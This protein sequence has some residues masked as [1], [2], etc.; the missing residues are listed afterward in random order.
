M[1]TPLYFPHQATDMT[2]DPLTTQMQHT[3]SRLPEQR[4]AQPSH[5]FQ[6]Y[7]QLLAGMFPSTKHDQVTL[8][9]HG[10]DEGFI[11]PSG[12]QGK[13]WDFTYETVL[14]EE[15]HQSV[16]GTIIE[17]SDGNMAISSLHTGTG[18]N[19]TVYRTLLED[20]SK[21]DRRT[22]STRGQPGQ[23]VSFCWISPMDGNIVVEIDD[24]KYLEILESH[25]ESHCTTQ[26]RSVDP[27]WS[28]RSV[29]TG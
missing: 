13:G 6:T 11:L 18:L 14:P 19:R 3:T 25:K 23:T 2:S 8:E 5:G 29:A 15:V 10:D 27:N 16:E 26:S 9:P 20:G 21:I 1:S 4:A 12:V 28:Q 22:M 24:A 7:D 17:Y